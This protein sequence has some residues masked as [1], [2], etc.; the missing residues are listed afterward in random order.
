[1]DRGLLDTLIQHAIAVGWR[2]AWCR[3]AIAGCGGVSG[4][5]GLER[6]AAGYRAGGGGAVRGA[7][8]GSATE[9]AVAASLER[10]ARGTTTCGSLV[11]GQPGR[12]IAVTAMRMTT[13]P[14]SPCIWL[15]PCLTR[16][17]FGG[18]LPAAGAVAGAA[19][20]RRNGSG[21]RF[22]DPGACAEQRS[23]L[24]DVR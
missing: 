15:T 24:G 17:A 3:G 18:T 9:A 11:R 5:R 22:R 21:S 2:P 19:K 8:G 20:A 23:A 14:P 4:R 7:A 10:S 6:P 12:A 16:P 13:M 1:V